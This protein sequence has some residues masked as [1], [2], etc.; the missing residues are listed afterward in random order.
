LDILFRLA[1]TLESRTQWARSLGLQELTRGFANALHEELDFTVER[2]NLHMIGASSGRGVRV[3]SPYDPLCSQ[4][5]LV[6]ERLPGTP[7]G[8]AGPVLTRLGGERRR[9]IATLLLDTVL[10]HSPP[11][12]RCWRWLTARTISTSGGWNVRWVP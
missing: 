7:L 3:P 12:M 1:R 2:D 11:V 5:V 6:M 10:T 8:D 4:R 9:A